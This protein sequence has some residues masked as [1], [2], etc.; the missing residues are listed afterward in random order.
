MM[1]Q[2]ITGGIICL[3]EKIG[4]GDYTESDCEFLSSV[5][6]LAMISLENARLFVETLEKQRMEDELNIAREIQRGLLPSTLPKIPGYEIV[7]VN[8][9]SK[10]V[11]GDTYDVIQLSRQSMLSQLVTFQAKVHRL[12]F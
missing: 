8:I 2:N 4:G 1:T 12:H 3:G 10:Q 9:S 6:S 5:G 7:A 11:G